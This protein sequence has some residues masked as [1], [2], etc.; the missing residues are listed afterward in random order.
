MREKIMASKEQL[1]RCPN[2][3]T[4]AGIT[5]IKGIRR[6]NTHLGLQGLWLRLKEQGYTINSASPFE[7]AQAT[8]HADRPY[9][10]PS[11]ARRKSRP[12]EPMKYP[13]E[14]I[15]IDVKYIP[16]EYLLNHS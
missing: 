9:N 2:S 7:S 13:E 12:Y 14:R 10:E 11:L 3:R 4:E 15:Q 1:L 16:K 6:R 8:Y 5:L